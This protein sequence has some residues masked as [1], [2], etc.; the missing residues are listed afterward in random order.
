LAE[1]CED[2]IP[3]SIFFRTI[4]HHIISFNLFGGFEA[5]AAGALQFI[6]S[7]TLVL[8]IS[9]PSNLDWESIAQGSPLSVSLS[10]S[11]SK[12][13]NVS[14]EAMIGNAVA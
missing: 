12:R 9:F 1:K 11:Y 7:P 5:S 13:S 10:V 6:L 3:L 8:T 14:I 4:S 2:R